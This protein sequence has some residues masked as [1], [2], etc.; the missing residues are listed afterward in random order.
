MEWPARHGVTMKPVSASPAVLV[1]TRGEI[2]QGGRQGRQ[3]HGLSGARSGQCPREPGLARRSGSARR[4]SPDPPAS[5]CRVASLCIGGGAQVPKSRWERTRREFIVIEAVRSKDRSERISGQA[6]GTVARR[7]RGGWP[8]PSQ[9]VEPLTRTAAASLQHGDA[10]KG[11]RSARASAAAY[12]GGPGSTWVRARRCVDVVPERHREG[13]TDGS[14][15]RREASRV[16][17]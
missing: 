3:R 12:H 4:E 8:S 5:L 11:G 6:P 1:S 2:T 17:G 14:V 9:T 13:M 15:R 10:A 7:V 16:F